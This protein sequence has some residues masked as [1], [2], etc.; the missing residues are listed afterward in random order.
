LYISFILLAGGKKKNVEI[1]EIF[2]CLEIVQGVV[3]LA[4]RKSP[5]VCGF[6]RDLQIKRG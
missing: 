4:T 1:S 2:D 6:I 5:S 3:L